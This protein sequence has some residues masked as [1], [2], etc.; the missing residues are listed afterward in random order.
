[1]S[2]SPGANNETSGKSETLAI[3]RNATVIVAIY[4]YFTGWV[5]AYFVYQNHFGVSFSS[6]EIPVYYFFVYSYTVIDYAFLLLSSYLG[7][8]PIALPA[9]LVFLALNLV[10]ILQS[11]QANA[12]KYVLILILISVFP[13]TFYLARNTA[14][15]VAI[16]MR[17][18]QARKIEFVLKKDS[19][20]TFPRNFLTAN[21][22]GNLRLLIQTKE[23]FIVFHQPP[24]LLLTSA[25]VYD[26]PRSEVLLARV[27]IP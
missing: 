9:V 18:G 10:F 4:L 1:M 5:Y 14:I 25:N 13:L 15:D 22:K 8:D 20:Q 24:G 2:A 17:T 3:L 11:I 6:L 27:E 7:S 12:Y 19:R 23:R 16:K 26:V 21:K